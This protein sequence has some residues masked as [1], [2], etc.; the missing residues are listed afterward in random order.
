MCYARISNKYFHLLA[1]L[2]FFV[3]LLSVAGCGGTGDNVV[4]PSNKS[5][6]DESEKPELV[7][8]GTV[9]IDGSSTVYPI[10][11]A[12]AEESFVI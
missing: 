11:E 5:G 6:P 2:V 7:L 4:Y 12:V 8:T 1:G 3:F 10:S 9:E